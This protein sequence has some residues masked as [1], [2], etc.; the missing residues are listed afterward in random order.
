M[1]VVGDMGTQCCELLSPREVAARVAPIFDPLLTTLGCVFVLGHRAARDLNEMAGEIGP[2]RGLRDT[3]TSI[4]RISSASNT[5]R[6]FILQLLLVMNWSGTLWLSE[7]LNQRRLDSLSRDSFHSRL[8]PAT[9]LCFSSESCNRPGE[10]M[11]W[12]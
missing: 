12:T 5:A 10:V 11:S 1:S 6:A 4:T 3:S 9:D 7:L 8:A 2:A